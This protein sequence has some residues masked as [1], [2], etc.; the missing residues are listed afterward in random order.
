GRPRPMSSSVEAIGSGLAAEET[1]PAELPHVSLPRVPAAALLWSRF[2]T[3]AGVIVT[4]FTLDVITVL[5]ADYWLFQSLGFE[6]IF[7]TNVRMGAEL[8]IPAFIGFFAAIA[9]PSWL[10]DV[11]SFARS[12]GRKAAFIVASVA[13]YLIA[14]NYSEFL[15]GGKG[16]NFDKTDPVFGIDI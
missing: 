11:S 5:F 8:Y 2:L 10:H 15:L 4:L 3:L 6:S 9:V 16:F 1:L 13:A 12:F 14:N 7:W